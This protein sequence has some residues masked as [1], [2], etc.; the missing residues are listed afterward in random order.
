MQ[1]HYVERVNVYKA[2][3]TAQKNA[4]CCENHSWEENR[5][6]IQVLPPIHVSWKGALKVVI[7]VLLLPLALAA[8]PLACLVKRFDHPKNLNNLGHQGNSNQRLKGWNKELS[9]VCLEF[10]VSAL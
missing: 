10:N 5:L 9:R 4:R 6:M 3:V 1:D 8:L 7:G 2:K